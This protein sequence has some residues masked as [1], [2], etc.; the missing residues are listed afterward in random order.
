LPLGGWKPSDT[1]KGKKKA[2]TFSKA[3]SFKLKPNESLTREQS[4]NIIDRGFTI[5][6]D[7]EAKGTSGVVVAQGGLIHGYTLYLDNGKLTFLTRVDGKTT[8]ISSPETVSG[9]HT[10]IAQLAKD[11]TLTLKLDGKQVAEGKSP[12][13]LPAM[14]QDGLDV[15]SDSRGPVGNYTAANTFAGT[16]KSVEIEL[17][18]K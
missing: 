1:P 7:F 4:P 13:L 2:V 8:S 15:G 16:V 18:A 6:A 12:S 11:G 3:T 9:G 10:A 14:P 17:D 5:T